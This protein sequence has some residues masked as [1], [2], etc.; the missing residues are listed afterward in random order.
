MTD[1]QAWSIIAACPLPPTGV[2][3]TGG[4]LLAWWGLE[5]ALDPHSAQGKA[6]LQRNKD[7]FAALH[8][9]AGV[10]FDASV[11]ADPVQVTRLPVGTN[12]KPLPAVG[13]E[14]TAERVAQI[15]PGITNA[16]VRLIRLD[17]R[18]RFS[19]EQISDAISDPSLPKLPAKTSKRRKPKKGEWRHVCGGTDHPADQVCVDLPM[20]RLMREL[21]GVLNSE[22]NLIRWADAEA[23]PDDADEW[24]LTWSHE[25]DT[26]ITYAKL[27][28]GP[29]PVEPGQQ[30]G[31]S[32]STMTCFGTG[33]AQVFGAE[34][35]TTRLCAWMLIKNVCCGGNRVVAH[36][37]V[38]RF[39]K[40]PDGLLAGLAKYPRPADL[41]AAH[42][43]LAETS[44]SSAAVGGAQE[45]PTVAAALDAWDGQT[46]WLDRSEGKGL[47]VVFGGERHGIWGTRLVPCH[48]D[49][50]TWEEEVH[51][52][53]WP[54]IMLR[55][56]VERYLDGDKQECDPIHEVVVLTAD[57]TRHSAGHQ[58]IEESVLSPHRW[59]VRSAAP[60][61]QWHPGATPQM[62]DVLQLLGAGEAGR[63]HQTS[64][65]WHG[66]GTYVA[67]TADMTP[68]GPTPGSLRALPEISTASGK[69]VVTPGQLKS[70]LA[71]TGWPAVPTNLAAHHKAA[72]V[73]KAFLSL[74]P[75]RPDIGM[76]VLGTLFAAVLGLPTRPAVI[77][78]GASEIGKTLYLLCAQAFLSSVSVRSGNLSFSLAGTFRPQG[79]FG[80]HAP[81]R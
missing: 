77:L 11:P 40:N 27:Y 13:G 26:G 49:G 47:Y 58:L 39:V 66:G 14:W 33:T 15:D 74:T 22:G 41:L 57:G 37:L 59:R 7:V 38:K 60:V 29:W 50:E 1:T 46:I 16:P 2:I 43:E 21:P 23:I 48:E 12:G 68:A 73:V 45:N 80:R 28:C 78:Q 19:A 31:P 32:I 65:G 81:A 75:A 76:T 35:N 54:A 56:P 20:A 10:A 64:M 70:S 61:R 34:A 30:P 9:E 3:D 25:T 51:D 44:A 62:Q 24:P 42:P 79:L 72:G 67:A 8:H 52:H 36:N 4:G 5:E 69:T 6:L 53:I 71:C 55:L 17:T 18:N 63:E